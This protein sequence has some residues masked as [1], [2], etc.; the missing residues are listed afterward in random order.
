MPVVGTESAV[1]V[2][3]VVGV[4]DVPEAQRAVAVAATVV[5]MMEIAL[6]E[7]LISYCQL[8]KL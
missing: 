1:G 6:L 5:V 2:V 3:D 7:L 8:L 4:K